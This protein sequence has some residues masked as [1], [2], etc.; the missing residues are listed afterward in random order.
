MRVG[1]LCLVTVGFGTGAPV[2][3]SAGPVREF[4]RDHRP[5]L[6]VPKPQSRIQPVTPTVPVVSTCPCEISCPCAGGDR[7]RWI[8]T[9][10]PTVTGW[11]H[12][13]TVS[14]CPG[15]MCPPPRR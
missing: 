10:A 2:N 13:R 12:P 7:L 4:I 1:V 15:G 8:G 9:P 11:L 5:G 3:V 14:A 6:V